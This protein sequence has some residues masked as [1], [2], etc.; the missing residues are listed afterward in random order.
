MDGNDFQLGLRATNLLVT[1]PLR[2]FCL[3]DFLYPGALKSPQL[4]ARRCV[5]IVERGP[6]SISQVTS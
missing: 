2:S 4:S 5:S 6:P 3:H 1:C